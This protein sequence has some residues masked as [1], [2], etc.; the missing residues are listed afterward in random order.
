MSLLQNLLIERQRI[1]KELSD[2]EKF[3]RARFGWDPEKQGPEIVDNHEGS[4]EPNSQIFGFVQL[5]TKHHGAV[6]YSREVEDWLTTVTGEFTAVDF[7]DWLRGKH[8]ELVNDSSVKGPLSK[9]ERERRIVV[10]T[11]G[12]GR[13]PTVY[14]LPTKTPAE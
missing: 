11:Q 5:P 10:V 1:L 9:L 3:L 12:S 14:R 8:G 13:R 6:N 7:R 2:L 4:K